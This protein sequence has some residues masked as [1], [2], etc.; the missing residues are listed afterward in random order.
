MSEDPVTLHLG[1][2]R[3]AEERYQGA[4]NPSVQT[5]VWAE[6]LERARNEVGEALV[7]TGNLTK[8]A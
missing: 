3:E 6:C 4:L 7:A 2:R 8:C 5:S 1:F